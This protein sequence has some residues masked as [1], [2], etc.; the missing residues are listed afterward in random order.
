[1]NLKKYLQKQAEKDAENLLTEEDKLFC[2]QLAEDVQEQPEIAINQKSRTAFWACIGSALVVALAAVIVIPIVLNRGPVN[3]FDE[4]DNE[5]HYK[6]ENIDHSVC[7]LED[8]N[9][10]LKE[11]QF[12]RQDNN[13]IYRYERYYDTVSNDNLYYDVKVTATLSEFDLYIVVNENY[14]YEF[15]LGEELLTEQLTGYSINYKTVEVN[16]MGNAEIKYKGV[17]KL[18]TE[19]VYIDYELSVDLGE[20]NE[21]AF[22]DD[23]QNVLKAKN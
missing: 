15:D 20:F 2:M 14:N 22:F 4:P 9:S 18:N 1:M 16:T 23:I 6:E 10:N 8:M 12:I 19:T 7:N 3:E 21:Q 13:D 5:I 11:F 17:V